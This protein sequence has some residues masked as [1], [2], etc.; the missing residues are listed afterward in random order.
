MTSDSEWHIWDWTQCVSDSN[1]CS[2]AF[3]Y[4]AAHAEVGSERKKKRKCLVS[5]RLAPGYSL[6]SS[7]SGSQSIVPRTMSSA[8]LDRSGWATESES[9]GV[10]CTN[11]S[12]HK[13]RGI[14]TLVKVRDLW[15]RWKALQH[16]SVNLGSDS[17]RWQGESDSF[18][19]VGTAKI[20]K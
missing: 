8:S 1:V 13:P 5:N 19:S 18:P 4:Q 15:S 11:L 2:L 6:Q 16:P 10:R 17:L 3:C 9:L 20:G 14:A 12:F 7:M